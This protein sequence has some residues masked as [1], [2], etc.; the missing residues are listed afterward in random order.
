[1]SRKFRLLPSLIVASVAAL[2]FPLIVSSSIPPDRQDELD[3]VI[4]T[5]MR[6]GQGGAQDIK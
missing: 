5:G 6:V 4:V 1:M 3:E 2:S